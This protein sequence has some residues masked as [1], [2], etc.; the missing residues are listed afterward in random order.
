MKELEKNEL[1][2][3][4]GGMTK[5]GAAIIAGAAGAETILAIS[6]LVAF[7]PAGAAAVVGVVVGLLGA[8]AITLGATILSGLFD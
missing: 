7:P 6:L 1:M 3:I 5:T 8:Q 4:D 2:A